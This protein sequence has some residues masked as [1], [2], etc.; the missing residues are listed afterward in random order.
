MVRIKF[1]IYK[2]V[3]IMDIY[4]YLNTSIGTVMKNLEVLKLV[5]DQL[6]TKKSVSIQLDNYLIY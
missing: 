1:S 6:K 2:M 3:G 4:K 5:P